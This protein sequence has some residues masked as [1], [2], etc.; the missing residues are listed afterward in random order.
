MVR[1]SNKHGNSL[2]AILD[3]VILDIV[4]V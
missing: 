4:E 2:A 1:T 3:F